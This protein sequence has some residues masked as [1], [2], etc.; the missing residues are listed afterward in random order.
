MAT[1][2]TQVAGVTAETFT[3]AQTA[4]FLG[5]SPDPDRTVYHQ[6]GG[7]GAIVAY[8]TL[9]AYTV[10]QLV[11]NAGVVYRVLVAVPSSN[12][13]P[14]AAGATWKDATDH[15]GPAFDATSH[16]QFYR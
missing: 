15:R 5:W 7:A 2:G 3:A 14:P 11:S 1:A 16:R 8:T 10:G 6:R 13:T 12:A 9:T 4:G